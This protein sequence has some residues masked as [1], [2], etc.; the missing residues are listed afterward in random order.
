MARPIRFVPTKTTSGWQINVPAKIAESGQRERHYYRTLELARDAAAKLKEKLQ[1]FGTQAKAIRPLLAD[2]ATAAEAILAPWG[3]SLVEAARMAAAIRER[4]AASRPLDEA[5]DEWILACEGLR[6]R[7]VVSYKQTVK[8]LKTA[9]GSK[10]LSLI[11]TADLQKALAPPGA[12][13]AAMRCTMRNARAL[14]RWCAKK[15]WCRA[16][17]F[18]LEMPKGD[19]EAEIEFLSV[20]EASALLRAAEAHFPQAVP[21]YAVQLF[22]GIRAEEVTKLEDE[23]FSD[24]GIDLPASVAKKRRRRHITP[25]PTLR[26]WLA[27][28]PFQSCPN[29]PR[30]DRACRRIAGWELESQ[31]VVDMVAAGKLKKL[32]KPTRGP[33]PQN[34]LRHSHASYSIAAG[35]SLET[36]L[37]EFGHAGGAELLRQHYVGRASRKAALE[38][39]AIAPE[40]TAAIPALAIA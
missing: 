9:F 30:V 16:E 15:G 7:T 17:V 40:G 25:S 5:A 36:M 18:C 11:L 6:D 27:K 26:A 28:Y 23:H 14:W 34:A 20:Q 21:L 1:N 12:S 3:M 39:F 24:E 35:V 33:W 31:M 4:E 2:Q 32:P 29:W 19:E 37:F 8:R 13:G 22:A 10:Q 38:Y